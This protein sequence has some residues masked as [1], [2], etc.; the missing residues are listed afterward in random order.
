[1]PQTMPSLSGARGIEAGLADVRLAGDLADARE[2]VV[3]VEADDED[4]LRTIGDFG[5]V[6]EAQVEGVDLGDFH[7]C[8][9]DT[10]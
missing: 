3:S 1:M 4:I 10:A 2:P 5:D 6:G 9:R 7:R 8:G